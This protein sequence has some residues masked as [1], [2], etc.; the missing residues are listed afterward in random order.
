M[1][2]FRPNGPLFFANANRVQARVRGL[3]RHSNGAI[4][5]VLIN[6]EASNESYGHFDSKRQHF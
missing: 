2:I 3:A 6:L 1:L 4:T 5:E